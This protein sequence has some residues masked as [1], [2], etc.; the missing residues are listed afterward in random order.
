MQRAL[1]AVDS[2]LDIPAELLE[3]YNIAQIPVHVTWQGRQYRDKLDLELDELFDQ[4]KDNDDFPTTS[5]P[6]P[7]E[8]ADVYRKLTE[9]ADIILSWHISSTL[10]GTWASARAAANMLSS[11][12]RVIDTRSV[13]M[14]GGLQA[15]AAADVLQKGGTAQEALA[16]G[17]AAGDRMKIR[18]VLN[19][20]DYVIR[21][22]R[23]SRLE[24][25]IG[26]LL[27]IKPMLAIDDGVILTAGRVRSRRASTDLLVN[28]VARACE[29]ADGS[30]F[31]AAVGHAC[32]PHDRDSLI[33]RLLAMLP[34]AKI[35]PYQVGVAIGAHG[36]PGVLG[37]C[38]YNC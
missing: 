35:I 31:V 11:D 34:K 22:G 7:G 26:S 17:Q 30:G 15:L 38:F 14:G 36:G 21:G 32:A 4:G 3:Q 19:T 5:Q 6:S 2:G 23:I 8:F 27:R 9:E 13:S 28:T 25:T 18:L 37:V 20:L 10:S 16:A 24:A 29:S 33:D 12:I 1:V